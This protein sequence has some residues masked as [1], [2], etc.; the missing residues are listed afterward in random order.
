MSREK[1][2]S[3]LTLHYAALSKRKVAEAMARYDKANERYAEL[4]A[5]EQSRNACA[6]FLMQEFG[7]KEAAA[8][9]NYSTRMVQY[10]AERYDN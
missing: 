3:A 1:F 5:N 9:M 6:F 10:L 7:M 8:V 2:E 4:L